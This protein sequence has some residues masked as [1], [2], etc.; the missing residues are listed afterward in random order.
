MA[1]RESKNLFFLPRLQAAVSRRTSAR[2]FQRPV[3]RMGILE[4]VLLDLGTVWWQIKV[5]E[6][7]QEGFHF[8][9]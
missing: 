3:L 9:I 1:M 4:A 5:L 2:T 8:M 6:F 7:L